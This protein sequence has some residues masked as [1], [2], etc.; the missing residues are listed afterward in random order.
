[1]SRRLPLLALLCA[2]LGACGQPVPAEKAAYLGEWHTTTMYL[3][4]TA[5][6]SVRYKRLRGGATTSIDG[7][8]KGFAGNDFEVGVGP[9]STTFI[10]SEPPHLDAGEWKMTVD[11]V[12]LTRTG[13]AL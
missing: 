8:L 4:I 5:D 11:G 7:P 6:G 10:V 3:L 1:V 9:L 12:E 13:D 2:L